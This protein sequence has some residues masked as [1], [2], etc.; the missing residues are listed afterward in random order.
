MEMP[1]GICGYTVEEGGVC[2]EVRQCLVRIRV[3][4][5]VSR[6]KCCRNDNLFFKQHL[7]GKV[8]RGAGK[9]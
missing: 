7:G 6:F 3:A 1:T 8:S 4:I 5:L 9:N 2:R